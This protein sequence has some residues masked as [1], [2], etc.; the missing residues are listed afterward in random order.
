MNMRTVATIMAKRPR[1]VILVF[2]IFTVLIGLQARN[3]YM[4]ADY[5]NYLSQDDPVLRLFKEINREFKMGSTIIILI[6]QTNRAYDIRDYEI[7]REMDDIYRTLYEVPHTHGQKNGIVSIRSL[8]VLI[9]NENSKPAPVTLGGGNGIDDIP[10]DPNDISTYMARTQI[11]SMKGIL[12]TDDYKYAVIIIQLDD[13]ADFDSVLSKTKDAIENRG[14]KFA[15]MVITGTIAMQ[16]A[17]QIQSMKNLLIIFPIAILFTAVVLFYFHRT[18]KGILIAFLPVAFT[19][20]LTFGTLG[21]VFPQLSILSVAIVALLLGLGVDYSIYLM[22][23]LSEEKN[24]EDKITRIEKT[25]RSTGKAV[26]LSSVTTI[27]GFSSLTISSMA[28]MVSFGF[29]C[30]VGILYSFMSA[31]ILVPCLVI[32]LKFEKTTKVP[33]WTKFANIVLNNRK[34]IILIACFFAI[35][36]VS[37]LPQIKTDVNYH[38]MVPKGIPETEAMLEYGDKFGNGGNFNAFLVETDPYG[39]EDPEVINAIYNMEELMRLY[40]A[41][42]SSIADSLKEIHEILDRNTIV[43]KF[44]NITDADKI[45]FDKIAKEG[46]VN[47]DHSKTLIIVT[48]PVGTSIQK[49]EKT[50]NQL[51]LIAANT[52]LPRNGKVSILTGQ[53][54]IYVAVNNKL[55]D[56]QTR[57]MFLAVILVLAALIIIFNSTVYGFLTMIPVFFVLMW[58]PGFLVATNIPLSPVTITIASIMIGV[59]IDY[60]IH[61]THRYREELANGRSNIDAIKTSIEKTGFSLIE[62]A[63]T[64]SAGIAAILVVNISAL[65]EFVYVIIFMVAVSVIAAA[66]LLPAIYRLKPVKK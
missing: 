40:G 28:P 10:R 49:I 56:E 59:G 65:N 31:M 45:I 43:E 14:T 24:I 35:L 60:G 3:L 21:V 2:T 44:S 63:F 5:A 22:N 12:F 54:A 48:L 29:G 62:A 57:S 55:K 15:N 27:I 26:L 52:V 53:D 39:L 34:R 25:L 20:I 8:A 61:I 7:L 41:T 32:L 23:R 33:N 30:A 16:K 6:N 50:V 18:P 37:V 17:N 46:I 58:E 51:N 19:L 38:S 66:M 36:S 47:K 9:R 13:N 64:T 11:S 42:V 4:E 1:T